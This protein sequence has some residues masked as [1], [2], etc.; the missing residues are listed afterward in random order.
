MKLALWCSLSGILITQCD[1]QNAECQVEVMAF[2]GLSFP[3]ISFK[4]LSSA[5][6]TRHL[7]Q[8]LR[9]YF[10]VF[11]SLQYKNKRMFFTKVKFKFCNVLAFFQLRTKVCLLVILLV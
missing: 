1:A 9:G 8:V 11:I 2:N 5:A 6:P 10:D 7:I 4:F 3:Q